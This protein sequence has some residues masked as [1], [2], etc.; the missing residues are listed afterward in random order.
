MFDPNFIYQLLK[1]L[2][3]EDVP[4]YVDLQ[5]DEYPKQHEKYVVIERVVNDSNAVKGDGKR[6]LNRIE[7]NIRIFTSNATDNIMIYQQYANAL[8]DSDI[9]INFNFLGPTI[10]PASGRYSSVIIGNYNYGQ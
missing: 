2:E 6:L 7:F 9:P 3:T 8:N 10:N 1:H 5:N 4:I